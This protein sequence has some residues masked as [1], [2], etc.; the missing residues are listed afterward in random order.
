MKL[1]IFYFTIQTYN[2]KFI[3][4]NNHCMHEG[5]KNHEAIASKRPPLK[6][7][8]TLTDK[9]AFRIK[10]LMDQKTNEE[11]NAL[12]IGIKKRGCSG[13]SYTI[14]YCQR[15][16]ENKFDEIVED[17]GVTIIIDNKALIA[18]VGTV[19]DWVEDDLKAEFVFNNPNQKGSCGCGESFYL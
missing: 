3:F 8:L 5:S 11:L 14:N 13:L 15:K 19:M 17:K 2:I 6:A 4:N 16:K 12:K 10:E 1:K 7:F 18:L 9:A